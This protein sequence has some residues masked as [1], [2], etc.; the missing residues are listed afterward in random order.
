MKV[1]HVFKTY[2]PDTYGGIEEVIYQLATQSPAMGIV[3]DVFTLSK[4]ANGLVE[5]TYQGHRVYRVRQDFE[6]ASTTFSVTAFGHFRKIARE[7]DLIHYHFPWPSM[8]L[9]HFF[10]RHGKPSVVTYHSDIIKQKFLL[11]FY[12]PLQRQFLNHV[13]AIVTTSPNYAASSLV[14]SAYKNK[15]TV[16]P[17]GIAEVPLSDAIRERIKYWKTVLP[18][19]FF[20]FIGALRYYKGLDTLLECA[21]LK[22]YPI[23]LA[24]SGFEEARLKNLVKEQQLSNVMFVGAVSQDDKYALLYLSYCCVF[25]SFTRTEAYGITLVEASMYG[26]PMI[27]CEIGTGTSYINQDATT[28]IVVVPRNAVAFANAMEQ[29]WNQPALVTQYGQNARARYEH[30]FTAEQMMNCYAA[31]YKRCL[32]MTNGSAGTLEK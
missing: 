7:Y 15:L 4:T 28:G 2:Y 31:L 9:M 20:L 29:L 26:K 11:Q 5:D 21:A 27:T 13:Q 1:L 12:K 32:D 24:G 8:D 17:I 22:P 6:A 25:P 10:A 18:E 19:R 3:A 23:V 14:L 30:Y 16:I